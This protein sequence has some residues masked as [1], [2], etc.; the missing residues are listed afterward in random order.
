MNLQ[1]TAMGLPVVKKNEKLT[2]SR[3][4]LHWLFH[5]Q[6]A[7]SGRTFSLSGYGYNL[8]EGQ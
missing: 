1:L 5:L 2:Y 8:P 6:D 3:Y 7:L 4:L